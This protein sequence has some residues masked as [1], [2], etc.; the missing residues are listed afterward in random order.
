MR[1]KTKMIVGLVGLKQSGKTTI[2]DYLVSKYNFVQLSF[3]DN[4]KKLV[5]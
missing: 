3:A 2:A 4:L 1:Y 5:K